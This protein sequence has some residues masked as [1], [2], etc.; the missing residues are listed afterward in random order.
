MAKRIH[1]DDNNFFLIVMIRNLHDAMKLNV[2]AD[3][4]AEKILEDTLFISMTIQRIY[5][6]LIENNQLIHGP[7]YLHSIM[8]VKIAY[9][10]LL[11]AIL[12]AEDDFA[13]VFQPK[14]PQLQRLAADHLDDIRFI[15]EKLSKLETKKI[16]TCIISYDE[17]HVLM[18][19]IEESAE[20]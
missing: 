15:K 18:S 10:R 6:T 13:A 5:K 8:N 19:P 20:A 14:F 2:D 16:D 1:Y 11:E 3:Y 12:Q 17:L 4:F 9:G 7:T